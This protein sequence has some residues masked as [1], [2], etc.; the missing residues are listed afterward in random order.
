MKWLD[1]LMYQ[2]KIRY[3]FA[4]LIGILILN[5]VFTAIAIH[6]ILDQ[7]E[8]KNRIDTMLSSLEDCRLLV[9][10]FMLY[11]TREK[12]QEVHDKISETG[13]L[14]HSIRLPRD[15]GG[16]ERMLALL[17]DFQ[18]QFRKYAIQADQ[19]AALQSQASELGLSMVAQITSMS[20]PLATGKNRES[21]SDIINQV[22]HILWRGQSLLSGDR[23]LEDGVM[24]A[25]QRELDRL[26]ALFSNE[27]GA[28]ADQRQLYRMHR[29]TRDYVDSF[30]KH[31]EYDQMIADTQKLLTA[32]SAAIEEA[33]EQ[34]TE[35]VSGEIA[36]RL[37]SSI[38]FLLLT[39]LVFITAAAV[40]SRYLIREIVRPVN[41]LAGAT[42]QIAA[43][44]LAV[45][46]TV[47]AEDELG[48]LAA[49]LNQMAHNL[50]LSHTRLS[51]KNQAL[52]AV[53]E[54]LEQR[55]AQRTGELA[56]ANVSLQEEVQSRTESE[57]RIRTSEAK[58][59]AMFELSPLGIVRSNV[60]GVI[61]ECNRA[62][63][64]ILGYPESSIVG[65]YEREFTSKPYLYTEEESARAMKT[66]GQFG[67]LEKQ[68]RTES[69]KLI[70]VR[71]NGVLM[72]QESSVC[73]WSIIAD[74]TE[75]KRSE[76]VIWHQANF[77]ALTGLPNRRM[78]QD[79][80]ERGIRLAQRAG[81][82]FAL[83]LLDLDKFKE[84]N[85]TLGHDKGDIIL[86]EAAERLRA[87]IRETD[88]IARLGGD[89]F[90]LVITNLTRKEDVHIVCENVL[91][92]LSTPFLVANQSIIIGASI[93]I[94]IYPD[95]AETPEKLISN[96]DQ[97]M[98]SAKVEGR[99]CYSFFTPTMQEN[100]VKRMTL[101]HALRTAL[102]GRQ[103]Q[104]YYQPIVDMH[105]SSIQKVEALLRWFHPEYGEISPVDFIP[106]AEETGQIVEIGNWV[107]E[108]VLRT[109]QVLTDHNHSGIQFSINKSPMQ[110]KVGSSQL[111]KWIS[112]LQQFARSGNSIVIEITEGLLLDA[113]ADVKAIL[114]T[115]RDEGI[116]V[117]LD[118]FGTGYSSLAYLN[119]FDIDFLKIDQAFIHNLEPHSNACTL[120]EAI[121][122]MAHKLGLKVIA[123]GIE[124]PRQHE[125][126]RGLGCD[127]GQGYLYSRPVC[128]DDLL[129]LL[130]CEV[131]RD[132][133]SLVN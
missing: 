7:F 27:Q 103:L 45:S 62:F 60:E 85:D 73:I 126:L 11:P 18:I 131:L 26:N 78:F 122:V 35:Q 93:G 97:A 98:Y 77:D 54:E 96:A 124:E 70:P 21:L 75:Q 86:I 8:K 2:Q 84:V 4:V 32:T 90:T 17:N 50:N 39:L 9:S 47:E 74:I 92:A 88:E 119:K 87:C 58:F 132:N 118:D 125:L 1:A 130:D 52:V 117:A 6:D 114:Y 68:L 44:N 112:R 120:Y 111:H 69:G 46:V 57:K 49:C 101:I 121:I 61:L 12:S 115:Y 33:G 59:R 82:C 3:S 89:E 106:L 34:L 105:T 29:D 10:D 129:A 24:T 83:V 72:Q 25:I 16:K 104:V 91:E 128:Q 51:E 94:T 107:V 63:C 37:L 76:E 14:I 109:S 20:A 66:S 41:R 56:R 30:L 79:R 36:Q 99:N 48:E 55:V 67:P 133:I 28:T 42:R 100:A 53:Q 19:A 110:F 23:G 127:F 64:H 113:S 123:E 31:R 43:G 5:A 95:D 13:R 102:E 38:V 116:S 65:H 71:V 22:I 108:E 40:L 80:L 81:S 15:T